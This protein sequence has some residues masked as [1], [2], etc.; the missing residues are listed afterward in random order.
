MTTDNHLLLYSDALDPVTKELL[1]FGCTAVHVDE[2]IPYLLTKDDI[3]QYHRSDSPLQLH[4][5]EQFENKYIINRVFSL[6]NTKLLSHLKNLDFS[7]RWGFILLK[8]LGRRGARLAHDIGVRGVAKSIL[9]LH[10]QWHS[11]NQAFLPQLKTPNFSYVFADLPA[12]IERM[13]SPFQKS[14]WS[15]SDWQTEH[16]LPSSEANFSRFF[17]ERPTGIPVVVYF[18]GDTFRVTFPKDEVAIDPASA[19]AFVSAFRDIFRS[20]VGEVLMYAE[21][22]ENFLFCSFSPH[23]ATAVG[24]RNFRPDLRKY[25][26]SISSAP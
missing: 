17:V 3:W 11:V 2:L 7:D 19:A 20:D 21:S 24:H 8:Q 15:Y 12:D 26:D 22:D 18:I 14:I 6:E 16:N 23:L 4:L 25:V 1:Q 9:P 5:G 13:T 10:L